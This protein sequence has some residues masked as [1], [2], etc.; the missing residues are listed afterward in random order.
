[1]HIDYARG[2][3]DIGEVR[4]L[5]IQYYE[6]LLKVD[7]CFSDFEKELAGLPG[8][9]SE[10]NGTLLLATEKDSVVGCVAFRQVDTEI[11]EM[12]RLYVRPEFR[13]QGRGRQ[14]ANRIINEAVNR[15]YS[16]MRLDTLETLQAANTLYQSLGFRK[17]APYL[18]N[19]EIE[20][21]Y[22]GLAMNSQKDTA[23]NCKS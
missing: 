23:D 16:M 10:P 11:C 20:L 7:T 19:S 17:I 15:N 6:E 1:M 22:W 14:L 21:V 8:E 5:F 9:Y 18:Q 13:A 12:K 2:A 3:R 4:L